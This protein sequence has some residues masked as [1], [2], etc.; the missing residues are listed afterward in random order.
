MMVRPFA[1]VAPLMV[2]PP[3]SPAVS[4]QPQGAQSS[5]LKVH[6]QGPQT[7]GPADP[8]CAV[9][10]CAVLC[11]AVACCAAPGS[12]GGGAA[13]MGAGGPGS[14]L[15]CFL[16]EGRLLALSGYNVGARAHAPAWAV[17]AVHERAWAVRAVVVLVELDGRC[18]WACCGACCLL[19]W[20][21]GA[22]D[23]TGGLCGSDGPPVLV[24]SVVSLSLVV[25]HQHVCVGQCLGHWQVQSER[26]TELIRRL[27]SAPAA[28]TTRSAPRN[29]HPP[30]PRAP[31]PLFHPRVCACTRR[32][33]STPSSPSC[34]TT[35]PS[36]T[37]PWAGTTWR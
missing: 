20:L 7:L 12:G 15:F 33:C 17:L 4:T 35:S 29:P 36:T 3:P 37:G 34:C 11:C 27:A 9:A 31:V 23:R 1:C 32:P 13:I 21:G 10:C 2:H 16:A 25:V 18:A 22:G 6:V 14:T 30:L 19:C 5:A 28:T 26:R 8:V 24:V